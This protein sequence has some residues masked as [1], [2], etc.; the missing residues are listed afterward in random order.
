ML[1]SGAR[2]RVSK[3]CPE[4]RAGPARLRGRVAASQDGGQARSHPRGSRVFVAFA[5]VIVT[6]PLGS[7][8]LGTCSLW[9]RLGDERCFAGGVVGLGSFATSG[10]NRN[11]PRRRSSRRTHL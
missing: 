6:P 4:R 7:G 5:T 8:P 3:H 10:R 11:H 1:R 2:R 9:P